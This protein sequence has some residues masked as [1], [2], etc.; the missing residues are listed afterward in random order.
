VALVTGASGG[1][2]SAVARQLARTGHV[3]VLADLRDP[4]PIANEIEALGGNAYAEPLDVCDSNAVRA[5]VES[6]TNR[7]GGIDIAVCSHGGSGKIAP[8]ELQE[9]ADWHAIIDAYLG[10]VF[11]ICREVVPPMRSK[12]WGRIVNVS[13]IG[14][15]DPNPGIGAYAAAKAGV[16]AL[17]KV[18][19]REVARDGI[20][21]NCVAPGLIETPPLQDP[22]AREGYVK[23][24][25]PNVPMGRLGRPEEVAELV[26]W[27]CSDACS[28]TT[29]A[30]FD[31]SGGRAPD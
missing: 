28:F 11:R 31:I 12:R 15:R 21:A 10:G 8:I 9:D 24:V 25:L 27:L 20:I 29:A 1:I 7:H 16:I 14:G 6:I 30:V 19:A 13:S 23:N 26:G 3:V 2:G 5:T 22:K 4:S 17:T 18:L